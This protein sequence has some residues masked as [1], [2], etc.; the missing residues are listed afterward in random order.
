MSTGVIGNM[1]CCWDLI[2]NTDGFILQLQDPSCLSSF[3]FAST[4]S[5]TL[6]KVMPTP[7]AA[8]I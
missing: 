2:I 4:T 8:Y 6:G 5:A 7:G 3:K 1:L